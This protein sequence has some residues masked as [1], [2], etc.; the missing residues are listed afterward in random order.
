MSKNAKNLT[1]ISSEVIPIEVCE[2]IR[3]WVLSSTPNFLN[4]Q[5]IVY[6]MLNMGVLHEKSLNSCWVKYIWSLVEL[7][8]V[9]RL[10]L[11]LIYCFNSACWSWL[12]SSALQNDVGQLASVYWMYEY[13]S[14]SVKHNYK[15]W[16]RVRMKLY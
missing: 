6:G 5:V 10:F 3:C 14:W 9:F 15:Y 2:I 8:H 16:N 12:S 1:W 11:G 7:I 4:Q 13:A